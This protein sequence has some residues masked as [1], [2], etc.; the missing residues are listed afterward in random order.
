MSSHKTFI[1]EFTSA[2]LDAKYDKYACAEGQYYK[3][4]KR[5]NVD[6]IE[7]MADKQFIDD[8][9]AKVEVG[10][11][12][13]A[14]DDTILSRISSY[15]YSIM[16]VINASVDI[17]SDDDDYEYIDDF[18]L[19]HVRKIISSYYDIMGTYID[20]IVKNKKYKF[21]IQ[22]ASKLT[23]DDGWGCDE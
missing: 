21:T 15:K 23:S 1:P 10:G 7:L 9:M 5:I 16:F 18:I 17:E 4:A 2:R 20:E 13:I 8:N 14:T 6:M 3:Y 19:I 22:F 12:M 11:R